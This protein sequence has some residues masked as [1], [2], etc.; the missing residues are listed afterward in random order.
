MSR[1][2]GPR[3]TC[4]TPRPERWGDSR[5][6][7]L[8][9]GKEIREDDDGRDGASEVPREPE[10][11]PPSLAATAARAVGCGCVGGDDTERRRP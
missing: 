8:D 1:E 9:C 4:E 7:C 6:S 5:L 3:C 2:R 11:R 10:P